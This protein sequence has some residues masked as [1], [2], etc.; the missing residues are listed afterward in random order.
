M[1]ALVAGMAAA[2]DLSP[3]LVEVA[4][5]RSQRA[6]TI[7]AVPEA[8]YA[9]AAAG[10]VAT[11][12]VSGAD[13]KSRVWGAAVVD[14]PIEKFWRAINDDRSKAEWTD[15]EHLE[16]L[17]GDYCGP[18]R[19]VFQYLGVDVFADRWWVVEQVQNV[20]LAEASGGSIR[21]M[22]WKS[23]PDGAARLNDAARE[24]ADRG[25]QVQETSGAWLLVDLR[26]G[27]TLIEYSAYSDPGGM[28]PSGVLARFAA[29]SVSSTIDAMR[30]LALAGPTC[31]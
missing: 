31:P 27:T 6:L 7:P 13:G 30:R 22:S 21:E 29:G 25:V 28:L 24:W 11:G 14:V 1:F 2:A 23:V 12:V 26:D 19:T 4:P 8:G 9:K 15:L 3:R 16:L 18:R 5:M 10:E 20:R 17:G